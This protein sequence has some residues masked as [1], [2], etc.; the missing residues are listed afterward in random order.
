M[1]LFKNYLAMTAVIVW[2]VVAIFPSGIALADGPA[3]PENLNRQ[4]INNS[5]KYTD[6]KTELE[7]TI[8][9]DRFGGFERYVPCEYQHGKWDI[10]ADGKLCMVDGDGDGPKQ[11]L[12]SNLNGDQLTLSDPASNEVILAKL[13]EGNKLPFL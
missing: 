10:S 7:H 11:C 8:Y 4:L 2:V 9:F 12:A 13:L 5:L 3:S 1:I 6:P